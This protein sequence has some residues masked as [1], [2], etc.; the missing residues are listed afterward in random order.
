M[1][2]RYKIV[3]LFLLININL[4]WSMEITASNVE[5]AKMVLK[6]SEDKVEST[7]L[8]VGGGALIVI[9]AAGMASSLGVFGWKNSIGFVFMLPISVLGFV[10]SYH[11]VGMG[12]AFLIQGVNGLFLSDEEQ[13]VLKYDIENFYAKSSKIKELEN[14]KIDN[15]ILDKQIQKVYIVK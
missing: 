11:V 9:G 5:H 10:M 14:F 2:L 1:I 7:F 13:K 3:L 12:G 8:S 15:M 6:A 4:S